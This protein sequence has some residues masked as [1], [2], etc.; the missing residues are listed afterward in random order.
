[1]VLQFDSLLNLLIFGKNI[2][3]TF[4][5]RCTMEVLEIL[6]NLAKYLSTRTS[7]HKIVLKVPKYLSTIVLEPNPGCYPKVVHEYPFLTNIRYIR[8]ILDYSL[9]PRK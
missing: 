4:D 1:M 3:A 9:F 6:S 7:T 2:H 8:F 5:D